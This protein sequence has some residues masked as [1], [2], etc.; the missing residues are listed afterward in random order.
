[1]TATYDENGDLVKLQCKGC[2]KVIGEEVV[3]KKGAKEAWAFK[4]SP[5]YIE[6]KIEVEA[7][8]RKGFHMTC[9]CRDCLSK[10]PS[11]EALTEWVQK[12]MEEAATRRSAGLKAIRVIKLGIAM[13]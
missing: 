4:R 6:A 3:V 1:M 8:G 5:D 10:P 9:G 7:N 2:G 13:P 12:D 11:P